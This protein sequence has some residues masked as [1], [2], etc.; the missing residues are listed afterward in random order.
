MKIPIRKLL[1][2]DVVWLAEHKCEAHGKDFLGHYT[3]FIRE[4]PDTAPMVENIGVYD[5]ETTGL[6]SPWSH[7]LSWCIK[8]HGRDVIHFDLVTRKEARDKDDRRLIKSAIKEIGKYD[9]LVTYYGSGFDLP[10]TRSRALYHKIP[11][12]E[13]KSLYHTDLYYVARKKLAMHSNRL[14][15]VCEFLGIEAKNHPMTPT[16]WQ[17]AGAGEPEA[18]QEIL[19]HNKEDVESTDALFDA[20]L[21][22]MLVNKRSI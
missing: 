18:L 8:E 13:F 16:L 19:T 6:K 21:D 20:L 12:P 22:H 11:F 7:M 14:G 15:A 10:W 3:C 1:K 5:I 9:R 2:R 17:R 4:A